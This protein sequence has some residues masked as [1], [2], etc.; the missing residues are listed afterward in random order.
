MRR[1]RPWLR[2]TFTEEAG[3]N[4]RPD[5]IVADSRIGTSSTTTPRQSRTI[6]AVTPFAK[7]GVQSS[8]KLI[9]FVA[10]LPGSLGNDGI[11]LLLFRLKQHTAEAAMPR[12]STVFSSCRARSSRS[13]HML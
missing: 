12:F 4:G 13:K 9:S 1:Q 3:C 10:S 2:A 5:S 7:A 8:A 11:G 6:A